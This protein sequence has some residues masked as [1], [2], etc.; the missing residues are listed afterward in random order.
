MSP[1]I[2]NSGNPIT[3][4]A[5]RQARPVNPIWLLQ[6]ERPGRFRFEVRRW[7]REVTAGLC[8]ALPATTDPE[9]EYIGHKAYRIDVPG[10]ALDIARVE[11]MLNQ[12]KLTKEVTHGA[13]GVSFDVDLPVGP[14]DVEAWFMGTGGKRMGAYFV[15]AEQLDN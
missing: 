4:Q 5:V 14:V 10:V 12:E 6:V 1:D 2:T 9:I 3:Q 11:L 15:Y 13:Q 7:P 8:E